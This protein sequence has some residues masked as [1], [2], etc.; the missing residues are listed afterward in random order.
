MSIKQTTVKE[1]QALKEVEAD[2][3]LLDVREPWEFEIAN[4]GGKLIP[5]AELPQRYSELDANKQIIVHCL[6][7]GRSSRA[8]SFLQEQGFQNISNLEGGLKAWIAQIDPT[9]PQY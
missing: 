4:L 1:L 6:A 7:G 9:L 5:L 3:I 2:F 8:V